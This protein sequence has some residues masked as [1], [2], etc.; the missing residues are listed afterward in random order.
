MELEAATKAC[1]KAEKTC[2]DLAAWTLWERDRLMREL[3]E[4]RA[5]H[6]AFIQDEVDKLIAE[7][8]GRLP[9]DE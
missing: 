7:E 1:E 4:A 8:T 5:M 3:E 6:R 2:S 9:M